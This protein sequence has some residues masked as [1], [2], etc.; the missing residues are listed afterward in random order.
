[1]PNLRQGD[2]PVKHWPHMFDFMASARI[3]ARISQQR[4][5]SSGPVLDIFSRFDR[6]GPWR[7]N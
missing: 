5:L 2:K 4:G 6:S 1:M 7:R 3:S